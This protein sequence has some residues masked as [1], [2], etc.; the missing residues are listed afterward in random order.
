MRFFVTSPTTS[1]MLAPFR[2]GM[3]LGS[4]KKSPDWRPGFCGFNAAPLLADSFRLGVWGGMF[5]EGIRGNLSETPGVNT[6]WTP[7]FI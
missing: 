1:T 7:I 6:A 5:N 2:M 4:A 3:F